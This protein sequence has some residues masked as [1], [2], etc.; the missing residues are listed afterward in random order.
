MIYIYII[1]GLVVMFAI[2]GA[3][4]G[5]KGFLGDIANVLFTIYRVAWMLFIAIVVICICASCMG[6]L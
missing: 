1:I 4:M 2:W 5:S 3:L 6:C